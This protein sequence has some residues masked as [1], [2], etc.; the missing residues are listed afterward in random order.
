MGV[1]QSGRGAMSSRGNLAFSFSKASPL[2]KEIVRDRELYLM[3]I[4]SMVLAFLFLYLPMFGIMVAF[5]KYNVVLGFWKS[6]WVGFKYFIQFFN[7]PYFLRIV[8]NTFFLSLYGVIISFPAPIIFA[9]LLNEVSG[10]NFKRI[11]Q[12]ISYLPHFVSTVVVVSLLMTLFSPEGIVNKVVNSFGLESQIFFSDPKWFRPLY[13]GSGIWQSMGFSAIIYFAAIAGVNPELYESACIDGANR[14]HRMRYITLP[15]I[16][17]TI[18]ILFILSI[19]DL[20]VVGFEK[21]YLM[22]NPAIYETADVVATYVY[23]RG[24]NQMQYDYATAV[25]LLNSIVSF[26]LVFAANK[27]SNK[28]SGEGLW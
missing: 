25:G 26:V 16:L 4:P 21:V 18:R 1:K 23:R 19:G 15:S 13:I 6:P 3:I 22:Y 17:P 8:K 5:K 12:S 9:L 27:I 20:F 24:I 2:R 28:V 11:A 10:N 14:L 7:D